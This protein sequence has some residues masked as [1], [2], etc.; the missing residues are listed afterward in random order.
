MKFA[1]GRILPTLAGALGFLLARRA[2]ESLAQQRSKASSRSRFQDAAQTHFLRAS[3]LGKH[4]SRD[5][6]TSLLVVMPRRAA[7]ELRCLFKSSGT[8]TIFISAIGEYYPHS[9]SL[10]SPKYRRASDGPC[11][12]CPARAARA[13][14]ARAWRMGSAHQAAAGRELALVLSWDSP[15][16]CGAVAI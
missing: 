12:A 2:S 7:S 3:N 14:S 4:L 9:P 16:V 15:L 13:V 5:S 11:R 8:L 10:S 1:G 6:T